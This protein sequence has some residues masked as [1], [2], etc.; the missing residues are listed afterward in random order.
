MVACVKT[1]T[2][3]SI[4]S[5]L[6]VGRE[7]HAIHVRASAI[8]VLVQ[9]EEPVTTMETLFAVLVCLAGVGAHAIQVSLQTSDLYY[10]D[11]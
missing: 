8:P 2:M 7:R 9:T 6:M 5:A 11:V 3:T 10:L 4:A 1:W